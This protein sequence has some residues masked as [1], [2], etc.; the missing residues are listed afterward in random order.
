VRV[1]HIITGLAAGGA[2]QQLRLLLR[3]QR[4]TAEVA[5]LT[6]PGSVARAIRAEGT[7]VHD[8]SMRG[9]TDVVAL[10]RL[11]RLIRAGRFDLVHTHLYRACV[12]GRVA[13]RLA[14]VRHIVATEH[15]LGDRHIEG[16]RL[17]AGIRRLYLGAERLGNATIAV[18]STVVRRL[19]AWGVPSSRVDLVPNGIDT[20]RFRFD[21]VRRA[22]VRASLGIP[23]ERFVVGSVGRL[24]PGKRIDRTLRAV[25]GQREV[26]ALV[27]G[28]GP[29]RRP[30]ARLA[31]ELRVDAHFTGEAA[32]VPG[33]LSAMDLLVAPS[34]EETFGLG[35]LE[36]LAAGLPV[37]YVTCPALDELPAGSVP[38]ARRLP[39]GS[40]AFER[41]VAAAVRDGAHRLPPSPALD[42]YDI[43]DVAARTD[44][45]Y[46]RVSEEEPWP[47]QPRS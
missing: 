13:A 25:H 21:P 12:Y 38:G 46:Q 4:V 33:L 24:V 1:L 47:A 39:A 10:P 29:E 40:D 3:H 35:V 18:S 5:V 44:A 20:D 32:D 45:V 34:A 43:A 11:V 22:E 31:G 36:A 42:R 37:R 30:L 7:P 19:V 9:N 2:E 17:S 27:V 14:G 28:D 23:P 16:R 8:I 15:S 6:N 41:A 26:T